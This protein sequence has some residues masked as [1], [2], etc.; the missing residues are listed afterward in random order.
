MAIP[1]SKDSTALPAIRSVRLYESVLLALRDFIL[2]GN[3]EPGGA[4]PSERVMG[5]LL[6]VSRPVLREAFRVLEAHGVVRSRPGGGRYLIHGQFPDLDNLKQTKL[7]NSVETL[8]A[9][10]DARDIV[11]VRAAELAALHRTEEQ[12]KAIQRPILFMDTE[13][14]ASY[15]EG[16]LNLEF[17]LA[18]ASAS[19]NPFLKKI[20]GGLI[21][22]FRQIDFKYLL[23]SNQWDELQDVHTSIFEPI[24]DRDAMAAGQAMHRHFEM[25]R[26]SVDQA[27][28]APPDR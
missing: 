25:L 2:A 11:E 28:A 21:E 27:V 16:D 9:L 26:Q 1:T 23:P 12:L 6:G 14:R 15:R 4:F 8:L 19:G 18:I 17:H 10:W 3:V 13:S 22:D 5:Q 7:A 20:I 24:R